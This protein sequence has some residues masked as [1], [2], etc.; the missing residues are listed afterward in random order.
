VAT[1]DLEVLERLA[2]AH[3]GWQPA[4][5]R[6]A[7]FPVSIAARHR[8]RGDAISARQVDCP[9]DRENGHRGP[10]SMRQCA[11]RAN[12]SE[13]PPRERG[14]RANF[15]ETTSWTPSQPIWPAA[16]QRRAA[17]PSSVRRDSIFKAGDMVII[18]ECVAQ[19][20]GNMRNAS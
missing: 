11:S 9:V 2:R 5:L 7:T 6:A 15:S 8:R 20:P 17:G 18:R 19:K 1:S 14:S 12:F 4:S 3:L 13:T 16:G 10:S